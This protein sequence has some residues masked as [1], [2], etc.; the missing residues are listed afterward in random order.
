[1]AGCADSVSNPIQPATC[2]NNV[3]ELNEVCDGT[4]LNNLSCSHFKMGSTG[5]LAC[6]AD[7]T[8]YEISGCS[9]PTC[10][11]NILDANEDCDGALFA[12]MKN[13]CPAG[14]TGTPVCV[15]CQIT[16]CTPVTPSP[17]S[18]CGNNILETGEVCDGTDVG[19]KTCNDFI[20]GSQGTVSC[21][22]DCLAYNA[23]QCKLET[24]G[25]KSID[26][27]EDCDDTAFA[28][29]KD[30]CPD[31][32]TGT[33]VCDVN[34]TI[35]GCTPIAK[36]CDDGASK[37]ENNAVSQCAGGKWVE[38]QKCE[39]GCNGN[40]CNTEAPAGCNNN[41]L[42]A[43]EDCDGTLFADGKD[44]CPDGYTG[45]PVCNENCVV[46]GCTP[47]Q[48]EKP[49]C[50]DGEVNQESEECDGT[51]FAAG[52]DTCPDGYTGT[53][54]CDAATCKVT[55]CTPVTDTP[56][57]GDG[58]VNQE[59]EE[60][61]GTKFAA[62]KDTCPSG[63]TGT[64]VCDPNTCKVT[65]CTEESSEIEIKCTDNVLQ[66]CENGTCIDDKD[67]TVSAKLCDAQ[68]GECVEH[69]FTCDG[70]KMVFG[71]DGTVDCSKRKDGQVGCADAFGCADQYCSGNKLMDGTNVQI[72]CSSFGGT[73]DNTLV[74]C[75]C[76]EDVIGCFDN[77][78]KKISVVCDETGAEIDYCAGDC[79]DNNGCLAKEPSCGDGEI[80]TVNGVAELCDYDSNN[81]PIW[82][83]VYNQYF[84]NYEPTCNFYNYS[85]GGD[86]IYVSGAPSCKNKNNKCS[87]DVST[88]NVA[89]DADFVDV[90][91]WNF[92]SMDYIKNLTNSTNSNKIGG[93]AIH[94]TSENDGFKVSQYVKEDKAWQIG[95]W[96]KGTNPDFENTYMWFKAGD[97]KNN[98]VQIT[99]DIK[100][101]ETGP[102][103]AQ[104]Q[105]FDGTTALKEKVNNKE[106]DAKS[107][108]IDI[109]KK[110]TYYPVTII[111]RPDRYHA[112]E[113]VEN[114]TF[115]LTG[116][117][118]TTGDGNGS[119]SIK[120]VVVKS[121]NAL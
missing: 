19:G 86:V 78:S 72:D 73:C 25:N 1:M 82:T 104:L 45:T 56:K 70:T 44:K 14:T 98:V 35:S 5:T 8:K 51:K 9:A 13:V 61:D 16:G 52:K 49:K 118:A 101:A 50:G 84:V 91:S 43:G 119:M 99:F 107:A 94:H 114:F 32:Y 38:I 77:G 3:R 39:Y 112:N 88:C 22:T 93:V 109:P 21:Q 100:R 34:C 87:I 33:P 55:G 63:Y 40:V 11:N 65:G 62:G 4:D 12:N 121:V 97:A 58:E 18:K 68:K 54:S 102:Q 53:P 10:G 27:G 105:F 29:G 80:N 60:C 36:D 115:K 15:N 106:V 59:S 89:T 47:T 96:T 111:Y 42:D 37:C 92:S 7:C 113:V 90:Y 85:Q 57:C 30:K 69:D 71:N 64:P 95:S 28:P 83:S 66:M 117:S 103:K 81:K 75:V 110:D 23:T 79:D 46:T 2:G 108:V 120:N 67:C 17:T 76:T 116:Y 26:A 20:A 31:G 24:C 48:E 74:E 6:A 41:K